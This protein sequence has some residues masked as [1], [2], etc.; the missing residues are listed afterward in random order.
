M[1]Q[2]DEYIPIVLQ[3]S[4]L[5]EGSQIGA[6]LGDLE[7]GDVL[8]Q[9]LGMRPNVDLDKL[10]K[11]TNHDINPNEFYGRTEM[12]NGRSKLH[13]QHR[14]TREW[15]CY[16]VCTCEG[17][18]HKSPTKRQMR[19]N[20]EGYPLKAPTWC[21]EC[22]INAMIFVKHHQRTSKWRI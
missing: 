5:D 9:V 16:R 6:Q 3:F 17:L 19:V 12:I 2:A 21:T 1:L 4:L 15:W 13:L 10:K 8:H 14:G 7:P 18:T 11:S 20:K 22:P